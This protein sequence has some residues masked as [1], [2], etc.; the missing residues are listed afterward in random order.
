MAKR[1]YSLLGPDGA[2]A[3]E[4]GLAAAEWYHT[5][6]PRKVMKDLM[7]RS[8]AP[9]IRDTIILY[10]CMILFAAAG[11]ALWPTL[12]SVPFWLAYGVLYGS[13]SDSR[14]HECSHGTAFKT[15][16]INDALYQCA[17]FQVLR[18]PA[19]WRWSHARHHTQ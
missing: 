18:R 1:D 9:A 15:R 13:A 10:G 14:W 17:S 4:T 3:V 19:K 12:W 11:I 16:W 7:A 5:E 2:R 8:D 6:V